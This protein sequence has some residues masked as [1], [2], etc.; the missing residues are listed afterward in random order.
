M[1][2]RL[3]VALAALTLLAAQNVAAQWI[4]HK[5][6][7]LP[8]TADGKVNLAAPG[9]KTADGKP[10]LTGLWRL[11]AKMDVAGALDKAG[12]QPWVVDAARK[13]MHELGRDDT[14]VL[15]L[16]SGPRT[17]TDVGFAKFIQTPALTTVLY[18]S[19]D[20][21]QIFT[22]GRSLPADPNPTWMGYSVARW[23]GNTFVVT[24]VGFNDRT[25][26]DGLGHKH[27]EALRVTERFTRKDLGHMD[28]EVIFE[29]PKAYA[30]PVKVSVEGTLQPDNELIEYVCNENEKS[31]V[32]LIGTADDDKK[33]QVK[34]PREV[35]ARYEGTF[36]FPPMVP[37]DKPFFVTITATDEGLSVSIERG[38]TIT[39]IPTSETNFLAQGVAVRFIPT[40]QGKA[41]DV[42]V[43]IVEGELKGVRV[44]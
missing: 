22:D 2:Q 8:R 14:G 17:F 26:L 35:L 31:R 43:T 18:E 39:A 20:Y 10:D 38:P 27:T 29:D 40:P 19:L 42:I 32:R 21:R 34:L 24:S 28:V 44:K 11:E 15:C 36:Q 5:T 4:D 3:P 30:M 23:E 1:F 6:P 12:P 41:T 33:L 37:G 9:P 13:F 16:P 25:F 7:G